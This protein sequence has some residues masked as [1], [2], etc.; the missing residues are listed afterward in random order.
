VLEKRALCELYA[1]AFIDIRMPPGWDGIKTAQKIREIDRDIEIVIVTAYADVTRSQI[2]SNIGY[3]EKLLYLR[4]PFDNDE[5]AQIALQLT[6]KWAVVQA[7]T[8]TTT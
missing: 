4:K 1:V 5:L 2:V 8:T 7:R 3:P 6:T